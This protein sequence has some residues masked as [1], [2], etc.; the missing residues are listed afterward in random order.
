MDEDAPLDTHG[1]VALVRTKAMIIST[2]ATRG[3]K[4]MKTSIETVGTHAGSRM[5]ITG[6]GFFAFAS[7][8]VI[9]LALVPGRVCSGGEASN[10][11]ATF[12]ITKDVLVPAE[13]IEPIGVNR[14]GD[15]GGCKYSRNTFIKYSGF[16][17]INMRLMAR[18][19]RI[20]DDGSIQIDSSMSEWNGALKSGFYSGADVRVYRIVDKDGEKLP[21]QDKPKWLGGG[22]NYIVNPE[23]ADHVVFVGKT[24]VIPGGTSGYLEGGWIAETKPSERNPDI[25]QQDWDRSKVCFTPKI[26]FHYGD[27][28]FFEKR[29]LALDPETIRMED[30]KTGKKK[31]ISFP[32]AGKKSK[33]SLARH[34]A[35]IPE[36]MIDAGESCM[37]IEAQDGKDEI[38]YPYMVGGDTYYGNLEEGKQYR[39]EVWMR[40]KGL[41]GTVEFSFTKGYENCKPRFQVTDKWGKFTCDFK[42]E[43][44]ETLYGVRFTFTGPGT[45]WMDNCRIFRYDNAEELKA[46]YTPGKLTL[47]E[48][49]D[50]QPP[51]GRKGV[52]RF[53]DGLGQMSMKSL[54]SLTGDSARNINWT[55]CIIQETGAIVKPLMFTEA[56]GKTPETRMVPWLI[57]QVTFSEEDYRNLIEYLGAP[58]DPKKDTPE[59]KPFAFNR[60]RQR[61]HGR[62]WTDTFREII[63]EFGNENW[64]NRYALFPFWIGFGE[65]SAIHQGGKE[66]GI[67]TRYYVEQMIESPYWTAEKLDEKIKFCL[68][69]N[70]SAQI[71]KDGKVTGYGQ[72]ATQANGYNSYEGHAIYVGPLWELGQDLK[73]P[74]DDEGFQ[75]TLLS[76]EAGSKS[77]NENMSVSFRK[78]QEQGYTKHELVSYEGGPSGF[79]IWGK[80]L[81][82]EDLR[83]T[84]VL[85][86][87]LA[88]GV[89]ALDCWLDTYR[90]GWTYHC[91]YFYG[92]GKSWNSHSEIKY[93]FL[94]SPAFMAMEMRNRC[95]RGDMLVT[96]VNST[97]T[98]SYGATGNLKKA[99]ETK[100][101]EAGKETKRE[102]PLIKCYCFRDGNRYSVAVL[103][104]TL[105]GKHS[106]HDFG[107][108][109]TPVTLNLPFSSAGKITVHKLVG[110]PRHTNM[111]EHK[112][113]MVAHDIP[114]SAVRDGVFRIDEVTGGGENGI[115]PGTVF[116]YVFG[117]VR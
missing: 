25:L 117:N 7:M 13:Q 95:L 44:S 23:T 17:P 21:V 96:T 80:G 94:P 108:G 3:I 70:Y 90:L 112:I 71:G 18:V 51:T 61:G 72:E 45:L 68:G 102:V 110:D 9:V 54:C 88:I 49:V 50:S 11:P 35:P 29:V 91:Y 42:G 5:S 55:R 65:L 86:H 8:M 46:T 60:Y 33:V 41:Q 79:S 67:F 82:K 64:H 109:C 56:T 16:E 63:L 38:T 36:G 66:Y 100:A 77:R 39:M 113:K 107:D 104:L 106:G 105:D 6:K 85:G 12:T 116:M 101:K 114:A 52:L 27:Y 40:Q 111:T 58:Y 10:R 74:L 53:W 32:W 34:D 47:N 22:G 59:S 43:K 28:L 19:R 81:T 92:Q 30:Q 57:I 103:S 83:A 14:C 48:L 2:Q 73:R 98:I 76:Y 87:S 4:I 24:K 84:Q 1:Q 31:K 37:K 75:G 20:L 99:L 78:L 97:P 26:D 89:T 115:P 69:G 93:G 15:P 62:P